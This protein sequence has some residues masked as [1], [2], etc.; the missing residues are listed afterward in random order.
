[1]AKEDAAILAGGFAV[2]GGMTRPSPGAFYARGGRRSRRG[3][4][5]GVGADI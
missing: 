2:A 3:R 5:V 4:G 1:M